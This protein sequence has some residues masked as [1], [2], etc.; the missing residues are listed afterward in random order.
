MIINLSD[1]TELRLGSA[2]GE[3]ILDFSDLEYTDDS[4]LF[5]KVMINL[6]LGEIWVKAP[7]LEDNSSFEL[8]NKFLAATVR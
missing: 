6:S 4:N 5:T 8:K 2:S 7:Q 1:G 3:S